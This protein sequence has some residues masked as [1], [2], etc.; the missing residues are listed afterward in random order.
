MPLLKNV[1]KR[2]WDTE[3][4]S[5]SIKHADGR[6]MR[7]DRKDIPMFNFTRK[8]KNSMTVDEWKKQRFFPY[9]PG[10]D[11]DVLDGLGVAVRGNT[12]LSTVRDSYMDE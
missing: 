10:F 1:E 7:G 11:V 6:D 4:F 3:E 12:V 5:V 8:A 9:Y 2:I